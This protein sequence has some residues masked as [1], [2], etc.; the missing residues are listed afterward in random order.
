LLNENL[1]EVEY[2]ELLKEGFIITE[3]QYQKE[4]SKPFYMISGGKV[5]VDNDTVESINNLTKFIEQCN[6]L[7]F[8]PSS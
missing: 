8:I 2:N 4:S 7:G 5:K 1:S 6:K 3:E